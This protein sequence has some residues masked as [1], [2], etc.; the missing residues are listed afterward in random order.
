M[1]TI[2]HPATIEISV[3][4]AFVETVT[5][6]WSRR[7]T[8]LASADWPFAAL[9][10]LWAFD[11]GADL[12]SIPVL[13]I[14]VGLASFLM[15]ATYAVRIHRVMLLDDPAG[16]RA[17]LTGRDWRYLGWTFALL[18]IG[19]TLYR[20]LHGLVPLNAVSPVLYYTS[21]LVMSV[22][23]LYIWARLCLL[24]PSTALDQKIRLRDAWRL[25]EG[26]NWQFFFV[27]VGWSAVAYWLWVWTSRATAGIATLGGLGRWIH[28]G[29]TTVASMLLATLQVAIL[30]HVY[31]V[32]RP[33]IHPE[34]VPR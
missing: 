9:I 3:W 2:V 13:S 11:A 28:W 20:L 32:A 34:T 16:A 14:S 33:H 25:T 4:T 29:G 21:A 8:L 23:G 7:D 15:F 5:R 30:S 31:S 27:T 18:A 17:P 26:A 1:S 24:L 10:G 19:N 12:G 6:L 22:P